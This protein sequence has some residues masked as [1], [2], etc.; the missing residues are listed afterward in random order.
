[1]IKKDN[2][3]ILVF[4]QLLNQPDNVLYLIFSLQLNAD[5]IIELEGVQE[6]GQNMLKN[7]VHSSNTDSST[8]I[9]A[10]YKGQIIMG[11][12]IQSVYWYK[13]N[14]DKTNQEDVIKFY[15]K[16]LENIFI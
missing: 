3:F 13:K 12:T 11:I 10:D 5:I 6:Y 15:K 7:H 16:T 14:Q 8:A 4:E 1:M 2:F 9:E